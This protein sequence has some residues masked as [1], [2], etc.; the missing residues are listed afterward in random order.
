MPRPGRARP[1]PEHFEVFEAHPTAHLT[2]EQKTWPVTKAVQ[3]RE[4]FEVLE[5]EPLFVVK[6]G[7]PTELDER[8]Q[9]DLTADLL[10]LVSALS[11]AE[12]DLGGRGFLLADQKAE[13]G[14]VIL[15][16]R[17]AVAEG[18][19]ERAAELADLLKGTTKSWVPSFCAASGRLSLLLAGSRTL[20]LCDVLP[21]PT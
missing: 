3:K 15:K 12:R 9:S 17:H 4:H 11:D 6:L 14:A 20:T 2:E 10:R 7:V 16:L 1:A 13:P 8:Q 5:A 21:T 18:A 19:A